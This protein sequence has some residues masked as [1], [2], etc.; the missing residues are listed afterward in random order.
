MNL[1]KGLG[2]LLLTLG[3]AVNLLLLMGSIQSL[4]Q[5]C[6]HGVACRW[7]CLLLCFVVLLLLG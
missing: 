6:M 2:W 3:T 4:C 7:L 5:V 1:L